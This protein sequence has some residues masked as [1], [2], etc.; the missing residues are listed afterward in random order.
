MV[1]Y[2]KYE[3]AYTEFSLDTLYLQ[4][5]SIEEAMRMAKQYTPNLIEITKVSRGSDELCMLT[6]EK[7]ADIIEERN[8]RKAGSS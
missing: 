8:A 2:K 1:Q 6:P 4:A 5:T 7:L 3:V